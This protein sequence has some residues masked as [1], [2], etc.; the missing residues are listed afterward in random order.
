MLKGFVR[1]FLKIANEK[2]SLLLFTKQ[3]KFKN[4]NEGVYG[5]KQFL[6]IVPIPMCG[7]I[8]GLASLGNLVKDYGYQTIG[9]G[10]GIV[11]GALMILI[12]TKIFL[13]FGH[14]KDT[15][16][17]PIVASV[18]PTFT[19]A[20]MVLC[21]YLLQLTTIAPLVKYIWL[22]A[23]LIHYG[24]MFYFSYHF[25]IKPSVV[26]DHLYPSWFIVYVGLGVISVTSPNFFPM[27]GQVN[28]WIGL[29]LYLLLLP[30]IIHR[31]FKVKNMPDPT[32]PLITI[33]AAPG[34]LLLT[35]YLKA[36]PEPQAWLVVPL[37]ILS[38]VLYW[39]IITRIVK[40][41]TLPFYPSYAAFT[42]P[43]VISAMAITAASR[44]LNA[45]GYNMGWLTVIAGIETV[46]AAMV[47]LYVLGHYVNFLRKQRISLT[48]KLSEL[49]K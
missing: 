1:S 30:F 48:Q 24:L 6:R 28:F 41:F 8:L 46:I 38:Q 44:F 31:V 11:A 42:F 23:I 4:Q 45:A 19:M 13:T 10:M 7:L 40:L 29:F 9:N 25:L 20:I 32:L 26:I 39:F 43:L 35:G 22:V 33:I 2:L 15:L 21:T 34:S 16:K 37:L 3:G 12:L 36:F 14:V 18:S 17:D 27:L 47:V 49:A 5:M